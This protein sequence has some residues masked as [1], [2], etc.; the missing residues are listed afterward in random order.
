MGYTLILVCN[1][2]ADRNGLLDILVIVVVVVVVVRPKVA[3]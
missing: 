3:I 1:P 2:V